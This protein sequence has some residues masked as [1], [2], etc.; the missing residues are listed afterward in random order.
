VPLTDVAEQP[1]LA[2]RRARD[3][4]A[5]AMLEAMCPRLFDPAGPYTDHV[6]AKLGRAYFNS[7]SS[8]WELGGNVE[9]EGWR[10]DAPIPI[11]SVDAILEGRLRLDCRTLRAPKPV[12]SD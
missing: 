9:Y 4:R 8:L 12:A 1:E 3:D 6:N 5:F 10:W 11:G 7:D 2:Q